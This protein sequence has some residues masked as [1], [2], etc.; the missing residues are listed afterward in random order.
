MAVIVA[1]VAMET[2]VMPL[3]GECTL[4][5]RV[6]DPPTPRTAKAYEGKP[7]T[8]VR[9]ELGRSQNLALPCI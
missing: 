2:H 3:T 6:Q 1:W 7:Q 8:E 4:G 5:L 9:F